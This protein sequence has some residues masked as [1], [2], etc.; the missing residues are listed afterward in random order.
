MSSVSWS[1]N[2]TRMTML[3]SSLMAPITPR[4]TF[5]ENPE[6]LMTSPR[7]FLKNPAPIRGITKKMAIVKQSAPTTMPFVVQKNLAVIGPGKG[8]AFTELFGE[9]IANRA[10]W[11]SFVR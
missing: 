7:V 5:S 1:G 8:D 10:S 11:L 9:V 3:G 2:S 6:V 4:S